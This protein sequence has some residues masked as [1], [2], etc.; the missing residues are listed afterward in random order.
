MKVPIEVTYRAARLKAGKILMT[1]SQPERSHSVLPAV[2]G[3]LEN[4][5]SQVLA[6]LHRNS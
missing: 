3:L 4:I 2:A 5:T 6:V 1:N